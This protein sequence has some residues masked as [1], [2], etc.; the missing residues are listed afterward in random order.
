V[1]FAVALLT[2]LGLGQA[3]DADLTPLNSVTA[4]RP[5]ATVRLALRVVVPEGIHLQADRP[6]DPTL[7]PTTLWIDPSVVDVREIVFP[8]STDFRVEGLPDLLAVFERDFV[9]G[10]QVVIPKSAPAGPLMIPA[11][12]R[13]QGCNDKLCYQPRTVE[14]RWTIRIDPAG[15]SPDPQT[16]STFS[17][18]GFGKGRTPDPKAT[19]P[20]LKTG[21]TGTTGTAGTAGTL[22]KFTVL[23]V[24]GGYL[25]RDEFLGWVRDA[26]NGVAQKGLFEGRGPLAILA[27]V[28][29]GGLAL[30]LTPCVLP[31]IP[32]NLAIIG[33]GA[34]SGKKR[35]GFV[36]G[37]AYG[38]AMAL[39]YGLL[40][41][42]VILT[43]GTFGTINASPWFNAGIALLFVLLALAMFDVIA[44][45]FSRWSSNIRFDQNSRGT[46]LL[47]FS[48]G[49]V[50]A[51]LAGACVA[52]VVIQVVLFA[53]D[54]YTKGS[55]VALALPF[56]LGLG[57]A[58]PWPIAGAGIARLPKPGPWMVRV[59]QVMGVFILG[60]AVYYG[61]LAYELFANRWVN[62]A[63]VSAS[64]QGQLQEGWYASIDEG[65]ATAARDNTPV[66]I[67]FWATWCKN[68]LVM[69][70]TTLADPAVKDALAGYTKIKFQAED[71][72]EEPA[73]SLMRRFKGVGL[74]TYVILR[75][76]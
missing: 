48:M 59:K 46:F 71:L 61:Y 10:V 9:I 42:V 7:I 15:G 73:A 50:A 21:T 57:M 40:G 39:V 26:E 35:R 72:D 47:A 66:L 20:A 37:S 3:F 17:G 70:K 36:L 54:L 56:V 22:D 24:N 14:T 25:G 2:A 45:D 18:I 11:R 19:P 33:A 8:A 32:I 30:N 23:G 58:L 44:V 49:A 41:L 64:A 74:P 43:A 52:P 12:L 69:D 29:I 51:L 76:Y 6:R 27:I 62:P 5:G 63:D 55:S 13:F 38:G 16:A 34:Q 68:C 67:D 31:M 4:A 75:P 53:S 28:F 60:T 65:L 1:F